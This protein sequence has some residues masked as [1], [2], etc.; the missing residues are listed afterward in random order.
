M[1]RSVEDN[2]IKTREARK[3]LSPRRHPYFREIAEG[4]HIGYRRLKDTSGSWIV[5]EYVG[6]RK[7]RER[8]IG[9]ADDFLNS[10]GTR[11]LSFNEAQKK[12]RDLHS[13]QSA[14][15][16]DKPITVKEVMDDYLG[17]LRSKRKG[18]ANAES[19]VEAYIVPRFGSRSVQSLTPQE[20][21]SFLAEL[22]AAPRRMRTKRGET[23]RFYAQANDDD[24]RRKRKVTANGVFITLRAALNRAYRLRLVTND[25]AWRT[26]ELFKNVKVPRS[27]FLSMAESKR[28]VLACDP[29][30]RLLVEAALYTGARY[31]EIIRLTGGDFHAQSGTVEVRVSK[32]GKS[33]HIELTDEGIAFFATVAKDKA[34]DEHLFRRP[35]GEPWGKDHQHWYM[36]RASERAKIEPRIC[37]HGL[38]HTWASHAIMNGVPLVVAARNLGHADTTMVERVYG[39][40]SSSFV[41]SAIRAQGPRFDF[42]VSR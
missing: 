30:F 14:L 7:Y 35:N 11:I 6:E 42:E 19:A 32:S 41:R 38:R 10:D 17:F 2:K 23:Q 26:V 3:R 1:A 33:R 5:R 22:A 36:A 13:E 21:E 8:S 9:I 31:S 25:H 20:L 29:K 4:L 39:H 34:T 28:L 37:F 18:A 27:R 15:L 16:A 24:S 12:A 40:L